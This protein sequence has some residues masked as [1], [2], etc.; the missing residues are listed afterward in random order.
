MKL[1]A[2][3]G[4]A[5]D[6]KDVS[7]LAQAAEAIGFDAIWT[8]ETQHDPFLPLTHAAAATSRLHFGTAVAIAF[9]RSP[10]LVA[11]TAW[12]LA[13]QSNG[14]FV[15]GLGTQVQAHIERR[16]GMT[17]SPPVPR[18]RE[19]VQAIRAIWTAWQ[20]GSKLNFRGS[21]Y[22]LTLMTPFFSPGP[23]DHPNIPLFIASVGTP[24]CKLAGEVADGFHVH[25]YHTRQY[26]SEVVLPAIAEGARKA[27]RKREAIEIATMAF[28]ALSEDE[29][30]AQRQQVA[31]YAS[32][33]SY[34]PVLELHGWGTVGEE[35]GSLAARGKW[36]EM[37]KLITDEMLETFVI[38]GSWDDIA[39]KLHAK[40]D[41][42]L[43]R[44]GLYRPFAPSMEDERWKLLV[45][46]MER[47]R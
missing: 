41:G 17:W 26:L 38:I 1:D 18:L 45:K 28:V 23:I 13:K 8:S 30:A 7:A 10:M 3:I 21:E 42:L 32:T 24:L 33:P 5:T 27:D 35:L 25:P 36:D 9:A 6:L 20:T 29:I 43:D 2:S 39:A 19:Y 15:L 14:R 4:F 22:K 40:Y 47:E 44:V 16:F 31:F 37:P 11:H 46:R 34:R 12:D